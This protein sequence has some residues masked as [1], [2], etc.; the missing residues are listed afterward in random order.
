MKHYIE[1]LKSFLA[2]NPPAFEDDDV[3][4]FIELLYKCYMEG[5]TGLE[6]QAKDYFRRLDDMLRSLTLE[7]NNNVFYLVCDLCILHERVAFKEG[8]LAGYSLA[9]EL[10]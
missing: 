10:T 4:S 6:P 8:V 2:E 5:N 3:H 7:E 1:K 9:S